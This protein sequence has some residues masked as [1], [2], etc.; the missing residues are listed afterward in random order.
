MNIKLPKFNLPAGVTRAFGKAGLAIRKAS[1][2]ICVG[3]GIV[4]VVVSTVL[5]C[6]QTTKLDDIIEKH[7][8]DASDI[9][10]FSEEVKSGSLLED[11]TDKDRQHD[12]TIVYTKTVV[13]IAKLYLVP[14]V[15]MGLSIASI[16]GGHRILKSRYISVSSALAA[17]ERAFSEYRKKVEEFWGKEDEQVV[18]HGLNVQ[19]EP[20]GDTQVKAVSYVDPDHLTSPY[21]RL[22]DETSVWWEKDPSANL[23]FLRIQQAH[24]N[25][26][27]RIRGWLLLNDVYDLLGLPN[28]KE[29][30]VVGWIYDKNNPVGDNRIDF[31]IYDT[32]TFKG[33]VKDNDRFVGGY[34]NVALLD[35]NVDGNI[36]DR[37]SNSKMQR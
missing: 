25:D 12:L 17:T 24:A 22:F 4:G 6:K 13:D 18:H 3:T 21:A 2:E 11:Y 5:A 15:T 7:K 33:L 1:P 28:T 36:Y 37:L 29:G 26:L 14:A 10:K 35:F 19:L 9:R 16:I 20:D 8:K 30:M 27:L 23:T 32:H 31:G 34:E